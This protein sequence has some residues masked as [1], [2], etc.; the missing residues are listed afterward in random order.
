[1]AS[2]TTPGKFAASSQRRS[3]QGTRTLPAHRGR[4]LPERDQAPI[5]VRLARSKA[6]AGN[7]RDAFLREVT[8][9]V[10]ETVAVERCS[11]WTYTGE[12]ATIRLLDLFE[13]SARKHS[14]G[15]ELAEAQYPAYFRSLSESRAIAAHDAR[16][17]PRTAEFS[18]SYLTPLGIS[19]MLD[20]PIHVAGEMF[21]VICLEHVGPRRR[22]TA[23]EQSFCASAADLLAIAVE[24]YERR[25][26]LE[27]L[28]ESEERYRALAENFPNGS[29]ILFDRDLRFIVA[30][31]QG[32]QAVGLSKEQLEGKTIGQSLPVETV[33]VIEPHFRRAL[34]G[35][36]S[37]FQVDFADRIYEVHA[38]P[39]RDRRDRVKAGMLMTQDVT[40]RQRAAREIQILARFPEESPSP[41]LRVAADMRVTYANLAARP[42][43]DAAGSAVGATAPSDW[44]EIIDQALRSHGSR[45]LEV[46][47][48]DAVFYLDF[49]PIAEAGY[50][51]IYGLDITERKRAEEEILKSQKLLASAQSMAQLGVFEWD[52]IQNRV[53][54][55]AELHSIFGLAADQF[56]STFDAFLARVHPDDRDAV[57]AVIE[58]AYRAKKPFKQEE[59]IVRPDGTIRVLASKGELIVDEGGRPLKLVGICQ[60]ITERKEAER[61]L[62]NYSRMLEDK[63]ELRTRELR[64]KQAQLVQSA[65]MAALGSLAAGL[66]HEINTPLGAM[67]ANVDMIGR[68]IRRMRV[69][70]ETDGKMLEDTERVSV[71]GLAETIDELRRQTS[72]GAER[73]GRIVSSLKAFA[74][75]DQGMVNEVDLHAG[76]ENALALVQHLLRGRITVHREYGDLPRVRC[77]PGQLNQVFMNLLLNAIEAIEGTGNV[78]VRTST[79]GDGML[80]VEINDDGVGIPPENLDRIFDPGFT[81]KGVKVGTGLGLSIAFRVV[82]SHGG[83]IEVE[84]QPEAGSRFRILLPREAPAGAPPLS[85]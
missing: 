85:S 54:W 9:T 39:V 73:I 74:H 61:V 32:L 3:R 41:I 40:E 28:G 67:L 21:G 81:T 58:A 33:A 35:E 66:A 53:S 38:L 45:S 7:D 16:R 68:L 23:G 34:A 2:E 62:Q 42:L 15:V 80:V 18:A 30:D 17:D 47:Y 49:A 59:R 57:R 10:A 56:G 5:L 11:V 83:R 69:A 27:A 43:L 63:V 76:I 14:A 60:D 20:A 52:V 19:S 46:S 22:W 24:G 1:M 77:A 55:S 31:G 75:L 26:A 29:V 48:G 13:R 25:R 6:L 70:L 36:E 50:V 8:E 4:R 65:K 12:P 72:G 82:E 51:N 37:V 84:S 79:Q 44:R 78:T 64:D 71:L